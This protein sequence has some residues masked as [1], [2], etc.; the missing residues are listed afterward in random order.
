MHSTSEMGFCEEQKSLKSDTN[1]NSHIPDL[2]IYLSLIDLPII[3]SFINSCFYSF[4]HLFS[5]PI[6]SL[7]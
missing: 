5:S 3:Y 7:I 1:L 6:Y 2:S 4:F